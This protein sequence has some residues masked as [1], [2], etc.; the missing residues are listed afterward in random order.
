MAKFS[1][2]FKDKPIQSS[3]FESG[4]IHIG[5]DETNNLIIDSL[6]I[7][8]AHAAVIINESKCVIKQ[9]N[10]DFPLIING[11]QLKQ[12]SLKNGDTITLGKHRIIYNST[13]AILSP[14]SPDKGN[15]VLNQ[16]L[17]SNKHIPEANLQVMGGKH[18]GR[19]IP[20]KKTMTRLGR[21]GAGI[22]IVTHRKGGY[23]VSMLEADERITVNNAPLADKTL[24]LK[25]NDVL[26]IDNVPMQFFMS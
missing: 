22:I 15:K 16:E 3:L 26:L 20:I 7:A 17:S 24:L 6:A 25:N 14:P 2:F 21:S 1:I 5:R 13:E 19:L 8:P 12:H 18:I 11:K 4:V 23:Y 9:L 10:A